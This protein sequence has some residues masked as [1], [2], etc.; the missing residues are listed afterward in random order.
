[1]VIKSLMHT[2]YGAVAHQIKC[3]FVVFAFDKISK[4]IKSQTSRHRSALLKTK[5]G[6]KP[7]LVQMSTG[8]LPFHYWF[9]AI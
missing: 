9:S 3:L 8:L 6:S 4:C 1:M 5:V 2:F 7:E